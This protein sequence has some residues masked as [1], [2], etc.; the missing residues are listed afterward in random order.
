MDLMAARRVRFTLQYLWAT[1]VGEV[2][3]EYRVMALPRL[4]QLFP[5]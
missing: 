5:K 4:Q 2:L 3:I 1:G